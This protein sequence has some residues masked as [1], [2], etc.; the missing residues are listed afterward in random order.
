MEGIVKMC[1]FALRT[2]GNI[3]V[4]DVLSMDEWK[5]LL[6]SEPTLIQRI[7]GLDDVLAR[8]VLW[9]VAVTEYENVGILQVPSSVRAG[10]FT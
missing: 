10:V 8:D 2:I 1:I 7:L 5:R 3:I 9:V 4:E 6:E